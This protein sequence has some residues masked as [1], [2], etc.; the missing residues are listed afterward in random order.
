MEFKE[1]ARMV[2]CRSAGHIF[3]IF[4][5]RHNSFQK[6]SLGIKVARFVKWISGHVCKLLLTTFSNSSSSNHAM[7]L[8]VLTSFDVA[9]QSV[10]GRVLPNFV[11][12]G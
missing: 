8:F 2:G 1:C 12:V 5:H 10:M 11:G 9:K 3:I 6:Q 7:F 4:F